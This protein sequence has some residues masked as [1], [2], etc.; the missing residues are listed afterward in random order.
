M[1]KYRGRSTVLDLSTRWRR[2]GISFMPLL[3]YNWENSPPPQYPLDRMLGGP[4]SLSGHCGE[5]KNLLTMLGIEPLLLSHPTHSV[6]T[7]PTK[8][9]QLPVSLLLKNIKLKHTH[10]KSCK[11]MKSE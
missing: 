10:M 2:C 8:L 5:E 7:I 9:P 3:I 6:V 11:N 1:E 4:Q